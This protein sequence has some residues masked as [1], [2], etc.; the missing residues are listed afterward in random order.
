MVVIDCFS[1][2]LWCVPLRKKTAKENEIGLRTILN[3][4]KY[5]VQTMIFDQGLEYVNV[6]V[7]NLL[8][9]RGIHSYHIHTKTKASSAERVIKTIKG[10]IWK[11]FTNKKTN[12]W[13][14]KLDDLVQNYNN[15]YHRII[16]M[17]PNEVTWENRTIVFKKMYPQK[18]V[19]VFCRLKKGDRVRIALTK[20]IFEKRFTKNWSEDISEIV[21]VFQKNGV[22]WYRLKDKNKNIYP[23]Q[24]YFYQLNQV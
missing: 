15:T 1:K 13:I 24:K 12:R 20:D 23:K 18:S 14:D 4:M 5:P 19:K 11:I 6:I 10:V 9:E 3:Q 7:Q 8:K 22:C 2:F 16:Q 21:N 17:K